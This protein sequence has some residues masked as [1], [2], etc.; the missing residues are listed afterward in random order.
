MAIGELK[1]YSRN[2]SIYT[3]YFSEDKLKRIMLWILWT[4]AVLISN[5]YADDAEIVVQF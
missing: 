2:E 1:K 5:S 4:K 3:L